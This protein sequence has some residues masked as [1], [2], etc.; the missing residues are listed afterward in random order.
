MP[1]K[2]Q[3]AA[4]SDPSPSKRAKTN[5]P[6][7]RKTK[8]ERS[9]WNSVDDW[10]TLVADS[11][12][13]TSSVSR[14]RPRPRGLHTLVRCAADAAA[15][16]FRMLWD[17]G[18]VR[19]E[20]DTIVGPGVEW[21]ESWAMLPEHLQEMVRDGIFKRWGG[22]LTIQMLHD[23]FTIPPVLYLPGELLPSIAKA[24]RLKPLLPP[25]GQLSRLTSLILTH[26]TAATDVGIAGLVHHLPSLEV[27]NLKGCTLAGEKTVKALVAR[28]P[29]LRR[30]NLKGTKITEGDVASLLRRF[31]QQ[32]QGFKVDNISFEHIN[33]TFDS[34]PYPLLTHLCLPGDFLNAPTNTLHVRAR[35][36][37]H[38]IG[39]PK[40]R[41]TP[42][43]SRIHWARFGESFPALTH[44]YLPGLLIPSD[45]TI[46]VAKGL[47]KF[48]VGPRGPPVPATVIKR[49]LEEG[50]ESLR[51][52]HVGNIL[53]T[54]AASRKGV[55]AFYDLPG[56]LGDCSALEDFRVLADMKGVGE[57][58]SISTW[59]AEALYTRLFEPEGGKSL[60][61][62]T[63]E[64]PQK[65]RIPYDPELEAV[66][67]TRPLEQVDL[68]SA[69]L[70]DAHELAQVLAL[71]PKLRSLDLSGTKIDE[72]DMKLVLDGC[73]LLSS[74]DLT[75]CRGINVRHR[76]NI[77]K[78]Y[79]GAD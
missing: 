14:R 71:F 51:A 41:P 35:I 7:R 23:L 58:W 9:I 69:D 52:V 56:L 53:S 40:P 49:I 10:D 31:G 30:I 2:R 43:D 42:E 63:L 74:V 34:S 61:R 6:T 72:D 1:A 79:D 64:L 26:S 38:A 36:A 18:E 47:T 27:I 77:F 16:G 76:R 44:L 33:E 17:Q 78:A 54:V 60:K 73:P 59:T 21:R 15:R 12:L 66:F 70:G 62:I 24:D 46:S 55:D 57:G 22:L 11:S 37:G 4:P 75:S 13:S 25:E 5:H 45:S 48:A 50:N 8:G 20:G 3:A 39:Y 65:I 67:S 68:P 32:L 19:A 28:C 29:N